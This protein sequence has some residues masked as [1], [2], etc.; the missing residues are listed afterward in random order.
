MNDLATPT[1]KLSNNYSL[2]EHLRT[3]WKPFFCEKCV[4][5]KA[6]GHR[7]LPPSIVPKDKPL[8]LFV[9]DV[10]GPFD[11]NVNGFK[12]TITLRN[13]ASMFTFV[14][15]MHSKADVPKR[16]IKTWFEVIH[17]HLGHYPKF[18]R[19]DNGG[20]FISKR[21]ESILAKRGICLVTSAPY[22]PKENGK[23]ERV[24]HNINDM[25]W[26]MLNSS[27]LPFEFWS[28]V[29]Q[30]AAYLHNR[31]APK[32]TVKI[33]FNQKPTPKFIFPF[34][35]TRPCFPPHQ[36]ERQ[37][38]FRSRQRLFPRWLPPIR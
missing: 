8:D 38:I 17:T 36:K 30:S 18:L 25:A 13:H 37:Q 3:T 32:T 6:T 9:S 1:T 27:G 15:P 20:E 34:W 5:A 10:M 21:F 7:F 29:Q 14:S 28:Y 16:L 31:I 11:N 19:C 35:G 26:V 2:P 33:L 12:F 4:L 24:N 22:H 23:A